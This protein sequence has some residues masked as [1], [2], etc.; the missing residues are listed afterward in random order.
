MIDE[1]KKTEAGLY[2]EMLH[3]IISD[4]DEDKTEYTMFVESGTNS[5]ETLEK[6]YNEFETLHTIELDQKYYEKFD[7]IIEEKNYEKIINHFGDTIDILP[8]ILQKCIESKDKS[9]FWLDG[10]WSGGDTALGI[11]SCPL[12]KECVSI[13]NFYQ[14][15]SA[16]IVID[17]YRLFGGGWIGWDDISVENIVSCFKNHEVKYKTYIGYD[18]MSILIT[19]KG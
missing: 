10:H 11:E 18:C 12:F 9:V 4:F 19:K 13:N 17:D 6:L 7:K 16:I 14:P 3:Q 8:L 5:G 1:K 2:P 15:D